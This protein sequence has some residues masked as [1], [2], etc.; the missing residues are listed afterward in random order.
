M[1]AQSRI[2]L[3]FSLIALGLALGGA[4]HAQ[5][6]K[7]AVDQT[8]K[9]SPEIL[10]EANHR[11]S[12]DEA[13]KNARGGYFPK[14]DLMLGTGREWSDN[15]STR[16][17]GY[18]GRSLHR[19]EAQL[20]LSQMLFDGFGVSSEV[21]RN[22]ARVDSSAHKVGG[23]SEQIALRAVEAYLEVLRNHEI[24]ALTKENLTAHERTHDQIKVRSDSGVGRKADL[25]Q[26][27]ARLGLARANLAAAEANLRE[28]E[29]NFQRVVGTKPV[30]LSKPNAPE[31][32]MLPKSADEAVKMAFDNNRIL[33]SANADVEA[34]N[35]QHNAAKSFL[36]PRL[37]LELG[38]GN[39]SN[40]D[41]IKGDNDERYAMLRMRYN[42]FKGLSD[43][44]RTDETAHL[45]NE[46]REV[47]RRTQR[48]LDQSTRLSWNAL[49]SAE[50]RLPSLKQ[51]ADASLATR[52][53]YA[54]QF[55]IGQRTLLDLLDSEN[56][57]FTASSNYL[58]GQYVETFARYR[59]LGDLNQLTGAL[60][61]A[62]REE[63]MIQAKQ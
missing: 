42:L 36:W 47:M 1:H 52:D 38:A 46:A 26:I 63:A 50:E 28:T 53:A 33:K 57:Y 14:V 8:L 31:R 11:L 29:I 4:A 39:N 15:A 41:G 49:V 55:S 34:A 23:V 2:K 54:K 32:S 30:N 37:D 9:T 16:A 6:L 12:T 48:Q 7:D 62:P 22:K 19:R 40:L 5:S 43:K 60:G 17:L 10:I 44:A 21:D 13:V 20:T 24:V 56:E 3:S 35:A 59:V 27:Q 18:N 51:H 45:T 58:N 25:D 61:V